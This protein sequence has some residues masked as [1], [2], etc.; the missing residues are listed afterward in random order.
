VALAA[1]YLAAFVLA[2]VLAL[3]LGWN[4]WLSVALVTI[5]AAGVTYRVADRPR[6]TV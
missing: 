1:V 6:G 2:H 5:A 3:G 4:P